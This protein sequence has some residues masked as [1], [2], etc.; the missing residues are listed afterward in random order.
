MDLT[1]LIPLNNWVVIERLVVSDVTPSGI[2]LSEKEESQLAKV[3]NVPTKTTLKIG[4]MV[5]ITKNYM[6]HD[7]SDN[8]QLVRESDILG[9]L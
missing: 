6:M 3:I 2:F 8:H 1:K 9:V 4:D 7:L 5:Y